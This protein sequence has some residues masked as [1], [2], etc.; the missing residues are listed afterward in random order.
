MLTVYLGDGVHL[1]ITVRSCWGW[2]WQMTL[3]DVHWSRARSLILYYWTPISNNDTTLAYS[4]L[5]TLFSHRASGKKERRSLIGLNDKQ[6]QHFSFRRRKMHVPS[7]LAY[8]ICPVN[9]FVHYNITTTW[10]QKF[11]V[12][13]DKYFSCMPAASFSFVLSPYKVVRRRHYVH[14]LFVSTIS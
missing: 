4:T 13:D 12:F 7:L 9:C 1:S 2:M 8:K 3:I 6:Q 10:T 14:G 5:N 11:D